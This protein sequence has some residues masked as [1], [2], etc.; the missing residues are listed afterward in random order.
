MTSSG[1]PI[2]VNHVKAVDKLSLNTSA[3][4][5]GGGGSINLDEAV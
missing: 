2:S 5:S 3:V 1:G 4:N